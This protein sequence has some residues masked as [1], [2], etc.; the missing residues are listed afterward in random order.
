[1]KGS[2]L[3]L[4]DYVISRNAQVAKFA[5]VS[6][7]ALPLLMPAPSSPTEDEKDDLLLACRYGDIEDVQTFVTE[8]GPETL[9]EIRDNNGNCVL[10]MV[11]ANGHIGKYLTHS[12]LA[13]K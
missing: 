10:H 13:S 1:M 6:A 7:T 4:L 5:T 3:R 11:C 12:N 9:N 8:H 2:L